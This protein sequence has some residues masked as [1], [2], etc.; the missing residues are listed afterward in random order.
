MIDFHNQENRSTYS[1]READFTWVNRI[2]DI[3]DIKGKNV[4][5]IGCGGGIYTKA[6]AKMGASAVTGLDFSEQILSSAIENCK[7][8]P[9]IDFEFGNALDTKLDAGQYDL[10]LE[11]AVIH[12]IHDLKSC[13]QE[14]FRLL[15]SNGL[16]IIQDRTPEDCLLKGSNTHIRGYFF[17]KY[18]SLMKKETSRRYS[19]EDVCSTLQDIGFKHIKEYKL[20]EIRKIYEDVNQL[21]ADLLKRTGRS[22]LHELTDHQLEELVQF[23]VGEFAYAENER[24]IEKDRWTIW[25]AIK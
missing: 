5:D 16:C 2:K 20:W 23:I 14:M 8:I 6:L 1:T 24:I 19:S 4:L 9:N 22:I 15:K 10:I 13:F 25:T 7:D 21:A 3:C 12:H 18:P 11:R 17:E